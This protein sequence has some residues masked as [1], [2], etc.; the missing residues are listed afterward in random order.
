MTD[1]QRKKQLL[2]E[3]KN[4]KPEM[5]IISFR[6]A[7]T[8]ETF[9]YISKDTKA[10]INSNRFKLSANRFARKIQISMKI[11]G[12]FHRRLIAQLRK[13]RELMQGVPPSFAVAE[14]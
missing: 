5:G 12:H 10:D 13:E 8:E 9:L 2:G 7:A 6:C 4:R 3:Y 14:S 11:F 1:M